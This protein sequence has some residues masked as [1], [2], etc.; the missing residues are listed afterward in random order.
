[1]ANTALDDCRFQELREILLGGEGPAVKIWPPQLRADKNEFRA[2]FPVKQLRDRFEK[3]NFHAIFGCRC[4]YCDEECGREMGEGF[5][6]PGLFNDP[7]QTTQ[8]KH[9]VLGDDNLCWI[10]GLLIECRVPRY[11]VVF[12]DY[13]QQQPPRAEGKMFTREELEKITGAADESVLTADNIKKFLNRQHC[14]FEEPIPWNLDGYE[15]DPKPIDTECAL[16]IA[17]NVSRVHHTDWQGAE[18]RVFK[19]NLLPESLSGTTFKKNYAT[20]ITDGIDVD[21]KQVRELREIE[22][23]GS[24]TVI[25]T[26]NISVG[27]PLCYQNI[28]GQSH[29]KEFEVTNIYRKKAV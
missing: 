8:I 25:H 9:N 3:E 4:V 5:M 29:S 26:A 7:N 11:I 17:D 1:M 15:C 24:L 21:L 23:I 22:I 6:T 13:L 14:Y 16:P 12:R 18:S 19:F 2:F 20:L 27:T 28:T 10:F